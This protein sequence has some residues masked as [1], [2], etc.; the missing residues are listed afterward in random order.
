MTLPHDPLKLRQLARQRY[1]AHRDVARRLGRRPPRDLDAVIH[2]WHEELF[3]KVDCLECGRCCR[4][5]G[6]RVLPRDVQRLASFW[7]VTADHVEKTWLHRDEDGDLV[8]S[9]PCP[10]LGDD[11]SCEVYDARPRACQE[12]PHTDVKKMHKLLGLALRNRATC[13][14][15]FEIFE[16]LTVRYP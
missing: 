6:P 7:A 16:R 11:N 9:M 1:D 10:F 3:D 5:L 15:V 13:P 12:Y 14:V 4:A 8:F 2:G